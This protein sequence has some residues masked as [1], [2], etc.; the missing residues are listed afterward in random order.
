MWVVIAV[1]LAVLVLP[2]VLLRVELSLVPQRR[3]ERRSRSAPPEPG[4]DRGAA[5]ARGSSARPLNVL[6]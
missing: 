1:P 6:A 5:R 2:L 4:I 3:E